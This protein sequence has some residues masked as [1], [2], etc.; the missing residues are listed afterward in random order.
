[1]E[2]VGLTVMVNPKEIYSEVVTYYL[3]EVGFEMFEDTP[4]GILA[5][6]KMD[7]YD[8]TIVEDVFSDIRLQG[9]EIGYSK[10]IF[11]WENW[12]AIWESNFQPEVIADKILVR[13]EFHESNDEY[14][15]ELVVQPKMA[16]GTGHHPTTYQMMEL[17]LGADFIDKT[18]LDMGCGTGILA[19]LAMKLGAKEAVG[20]DYDPIAVENSI[21]N[22]IRN[23]FP[24]LSFIVGEGDAVK[25]NVYDIV[26][27]NINRNIILN[28]LKWY[29]SYCKINGL[30][31][32]SGFYVNDLDAIKTEAEKFGFVIDKV[33]DKNEWCCVTFKKEN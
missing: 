24:D 1:M 27:A 2:Y 5:Y 11:P 26:L 15:Y 10:K 6:C 7:L 31:F 3:S 12:N 30:L 25:G 33:S 4:D 19:I 23:G 16:F 9:C 32:L 17:S 20:V 28:D 14:P 22:A 8:E 13:A 29:A 18:V 21:E